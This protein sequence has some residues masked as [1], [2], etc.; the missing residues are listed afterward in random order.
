[1]RTRFLNRIS[2]MMCFPCKNE[3]FIGA[4]DRVTASCARTGTPRSAGTASASALLPAPSADTAKASRNPLRDRH[5]RSATGAWVAAAEADTGQH[6]WSIDERRPSCVKTEWSG[7]SDS[8]RSCRIYDR[9]RRCLGFWPYL[10]HV[11]G[12]TDRHTSGLGAELDSAASTAFWISCGKQ[13]VA[14]G[15]TP[16]VH[17]R[18]CR[19]EVLTVPPVEN[20]R[21]LHAAA[22]RQR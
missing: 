5:T 10:R 1:M 13:W 15:N 9:F 2:K 20:T 19:G 3:P 12:P 21:S 18:D 22:R 8:V 14:A 4:S 7:G 16:R 17:M 11:T 6:P